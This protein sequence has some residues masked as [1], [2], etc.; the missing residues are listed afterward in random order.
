MCV[1][2]LERKLTNLSE[3]VELKKEEV[4]IN[5]R[6]LHTLLL[7][8]E[9]FLLKKMDDIVTLARQEVAEKANLRESNNVSQENTQISEELEDCPDDQEHEMLSPI[10]RGIEVSYIELEWN[11]GKLERP[12]IE[13]CKVVC[14]RKKPSKEVDYSVKLSPLW[15]HDGTGSGEITNPM[16]LVVDDTTQNI[17]VADISAS[18]IQV[19]SGEGSYLYKIPTP[20]YPIGV[21]L[22]DEYIFVSTDNKLVL[23][24]DKSSR[25]SLKSVD[26]QNQVFGIEISTK[27]DIY[28]CEYSNQ[29]VIVFDN[30]LTFLRRIKLRSIQVVSDTYTNSIK[31]YE[32]NMYVI[33]GGHSPIFHLRIF[34]LEGEQGM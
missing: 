32:A 9:T 34:T 17:F 2:E 16:Q 21:A 7:L 26:T 31:L 5:F 6:Q 3:L 25:E 8:R 24:I 22:T 19:F 28:V 29:S 14:L 15:S 18:R 12:L 10:P 13:I 27:T 11:L 20:P 1:D 30:D 33:F 23:K 4:R